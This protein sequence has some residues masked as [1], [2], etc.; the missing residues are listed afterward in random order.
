[1]G[2]K[3]ISKDSLLNLEL[4]AKKATKGP[5]SYYFHNKDSYGVT[6]PINENFPDRSNKLLHVTNDW[7]SEVMSIDKDDAA[8]I[9][10][11]NPE[12]IL[13]LIDHIEE[14]KEL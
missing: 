10:A 11:A 2:H 14:L 5:W 7:Y 9:A 13:K 3:M 12:M 8:Y 1:M 4:L 6:T